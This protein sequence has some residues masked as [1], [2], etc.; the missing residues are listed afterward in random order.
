M[1]KGYTGSTVADAAAK[2]AVTVEIVSGPNPGHGFIVQP[3]RW[4]VERTNGWINHCRRLDRHYE[5]TLQANEGFLVLSQIA[6]LIRRFNRSQ[7]FD[8]L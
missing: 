8:T 6:L 3:P 5:V 7:L 2:A 4:V 1:D